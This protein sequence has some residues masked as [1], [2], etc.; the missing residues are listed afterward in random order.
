MSS[1]GLPCDPAWP[2]SE[3]PSI[4]DLILASDAVPGTS[5]GSVVSRPRKRSSPER[6]PAVPRLTNG[7]LTAL[8][9]A[10]WEMQLVAVNQ[11]LQAKTKAVASAASEGYKELPGKR[12]WPTRP[13]EHGQKQP[14]QR[15]ER[16]DRSARQKHRPR[17]QR[18]WRP[19]K[20]KPRRER[21]T[22]RQKQRPPSRPREPA[23]RPKRPNCGRQTTGCWPRWRRPSDWPRDRTVA[24]Q[25]S[26][27][28]EERGPGRRPDQD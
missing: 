4:Q 21:P 10:R 24:C 19:A 9:Q 17:S 15:S 22:S 1:V 2:G 20:S 8:A 27:P 7:A 13:Y 26:G 14:W 28:V 18:P 11:T 3:N 25:A 12:N 16:V 23:Q 6:K 5:D